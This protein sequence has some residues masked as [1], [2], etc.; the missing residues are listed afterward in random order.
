MTPELFESGAARE[1]A[2]EVNLVR[3]SADHCQSV[4]IEEKTVSRIAAK[5][6]TDAALAATRSVSTTTAR[7]GSPRLF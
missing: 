2:K 3:S 6:R 7:L 4:P 1:F 5:L